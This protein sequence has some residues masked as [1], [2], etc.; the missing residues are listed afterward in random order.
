MFFLFHPLTPSPTQ[1]SPRTL[2][3]VAKKVNLIRP[4][5]LLELEKRSKPWL[6]LGGLHRRSRFPEERHSGQAQH[7]RQPLDVP[8]Q[9][10]EDTGVEVDFCALGERGIATTSPF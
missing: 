4:G 7:F 1:E 6:D 2:N 3:G 8:A 9:A 5:G 10:R